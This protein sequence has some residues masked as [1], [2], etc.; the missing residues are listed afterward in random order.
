MFL[1]TSAAQ[2]ADVNLNDWV[3]ENYPPVSGFS[4]ANWMVNGPGGESVTQTINGQPTIFYADTQAQGTQVTGKASVITNS[5]NDFFGFVLGFNPGDTMNSA[6]DY[7]LVDWKQADQNFNFTGGTANLT[8]GSTAT[9]GLAVSRVS[10]IPTADELWG[11]FDGAGNANGGVQELA[12]ASTSL[13]STGW[14]NFEEY[15]FSFDFG[16]NN[17]VIKVNGVEQFNLAG[18]FSNGRIGF[19]NFSQDTVKY[20][21]FTTDPGSFAVPL[22]ASAWLLIA[23]FGGLGLA[24]RRKA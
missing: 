15:E 24:K 12:R 2:A 16:P 1:A 18:S 6:A 23:A 9:A 14:N 3:A 20:S 7:L 5:D 4:G 19:Y 8:P 22:P 11:H 13:G 17:L 10:G 21:A